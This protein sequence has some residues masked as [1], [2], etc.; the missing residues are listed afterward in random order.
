MGPYLQFH[1][2]WEEK[3]GTRKTG[4]VA[5]VIKFSKVYFKNNEYLGIHVAKFVFEA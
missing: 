5:V 3:S 4:K 2:K 1:M